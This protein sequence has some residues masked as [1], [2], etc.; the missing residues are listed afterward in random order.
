MDLGIRYIHVP[1]SESWG[2]LGDTSNV[3]IDDGTEGFTLA[4]G[5]VEFFRGRLTTS[6][7]ASNL[8]QKSSSKKN[9]SSILRSDR[10]KQLV[11]DDLRCWRPMP[12][13]PKPHCYHSSED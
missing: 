12:I 6:V 2:L 9:E 3:L 1:L 5:D 10:V 13:H 8:I 4:E 7:S 11:A